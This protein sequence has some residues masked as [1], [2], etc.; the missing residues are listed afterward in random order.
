M[1]DST[2]EQDIHGKLSIEI[3]AESRCCKTFVLNDISKDEFQ[4]C[5][6][7]KFSGNLLGHCEKFPLFNLPVTL[8]ITHEGSDGWLGE[9]AKINMNENK[10]Y[11]CDLN[12]NDVLEDQSLLV[13]CN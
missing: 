11:K 4:N 12:L 10:N 1:G 2:I 9:Y 6:L 7:D 8:K 5:A 3:C 13:T